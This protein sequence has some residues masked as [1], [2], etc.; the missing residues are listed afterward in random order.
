MK[1]VAVAAVIGAIASMGS[2]GTISTTSGPALQN[3]EN[4]KSSPAVQKQGD[5]KQDKR[6]NIV[7]GGRRLSKMRKRQHAPNTANN[8]ERA[9]RAKLK[10]A[11]NQLNAKRKRKEI[12]KRARQ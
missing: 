6:S 3:G 5:K 8:L 4:V 11:K 2:M 7:G 12:A 9:R 10:I 1:K